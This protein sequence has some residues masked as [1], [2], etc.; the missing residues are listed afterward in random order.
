[1]RKLG[2]S[3][4]DETH[5]SSVIL[6][7]VAESRIHTDH[8]TDSSPPG[9]SPTGLVVPPDAQAQ[10]TPAVPRDSNP[11]ILR[12]SNPVILREVAES[13]IH[14]D[15]STDSS[16]PG[17]S[18]VEEAVVTTQLGRAPRGAVRVAWSCPWGKPGVVKTAPRL[19]DGTPFPTMYY[20]TCPMAVKACST[21]EGQGVMA[22]MTKSLHHDPDMADRYQ[23][24]HESYLADR[25]DLAQ[26]LGVD[27]PEI[28]GISAGGMPTRVK[29]LHTVVA[30]SLAKGAGVN[31]FGDQALE[32]I[33]GFWESCLND[34]CVTD[35]S[36]QEMVP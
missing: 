36:S 25:D 12:D 29:C 31:P 9:L 5:A 14:I 18:P 26:E 21:L 8:S 35:S 24:A 30:H 13:R 16:P 17:L 2:L 20:L 6:R 28:T 22:E 7:E 11:V 1:V 27:V 10:A 3:P 4:T 34:S 19:A 33:G 32:L 23:A 15:H